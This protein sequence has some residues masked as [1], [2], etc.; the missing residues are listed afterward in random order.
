M[1][2]SEVEGSPVDVISVARMAQGGRWRTEAMRS[3]DRPVLTWF[4]RGQGRLTVSGR[5][6]GYGPHNLVFLPA[7]TM[8]GFTTTGPVLGSVVF[9]PKDEAF[10]WP[11]EPL[12][13]RLHEVQAQR[14]LTGLIDDMQRELST[15]APLMD[16]ALGFHAGLLSVW[17]SR[18]A[19]AQTG[20]D[21]EAATASELTAADRLAE[22]YTA[23]VERDFRN[24]EGVQHY[25]ALLGVTPTH[26]S[27]VCRKVSGRPALDILVDRRHFEAKRLLSD[28]KMQISQIAQS[29]GFASAAYFTRAFRARTGLSP[30]E[31]RNQG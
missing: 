1:L 12:H 3:Y 6:T 14:E 21:G 20:A 15:G 2:P 28:T 11:A 5:N 17:L 31:F 10:D 19:E 24:T 22:A 29:C 8:H 4:T 13:L 27:R 18:T 26:L 7:N 9:L 23:L 25:A 30:S 16:R